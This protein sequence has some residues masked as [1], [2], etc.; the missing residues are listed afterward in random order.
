MHVLRQLR[1]GFC[2][3]VLHYAC[4][5]VHSS[6]YTKLSTTRNRNLLHIKYEYHIKRDHTIVRSLGAWQSSTWTAKILNSTKMFAIQQTFMERLF[7]AH[8]LK[9]RPSSLTSW[10]GWQST[11]HTL[12]FYFPVIKSTQTDLASNESPSNWLSLQLTQ[13][14]H[15]VRIQWY[16]M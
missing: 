4:M 11:K 5:T 13:S 3:I 15:H 7:A 12:P 2:T 6:F 1:R 8:R 10:L 9:S 16:I 14:K